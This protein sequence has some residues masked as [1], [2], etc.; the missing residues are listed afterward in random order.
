MPKFISI[1]ETDGFN[2]RT[3]KA[4]KFAKGYVIGGSYSADQGNSMSF[5]F[6]GD[7]GA[8]SIKNG[9]VVSL[10]YDAWSPVAGSEAVASTNA[11]KVLGY[12][13]QP[14]PQTCQSAAIARV[15]GTTD[16]MKVRNSLT[17]MGAAGDPAVMG[18]YLKPLIKEYKYSGN[19]SLDEAIAALKAGY[20][21][22]THGWFT[23]SG[24]VIGL[25]GF[26]GKN[27]NAE[28]PWAAFSFPSWSYDFNKSGDNQQYSALGIYASC[29][30]GQSVSDSYRVYQCGKVDFAAKGMY[31]HMCKN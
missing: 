2:K 25:S 16:V 23:G 29:V 12:V 9:D 26:D 7:L 18:A 1:I 20:Q 17:S 6:A 13:M 10:A 11:S 22:I 19:A 27:F 15:L 3:G 8:L 21:L 14:D 4:V 31:L 24:H 28:D 30:V 5:K